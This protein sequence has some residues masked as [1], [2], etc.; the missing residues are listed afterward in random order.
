MSVYKPDHYC[1]IEDN[2][3]RWCPFQV[4]VYEYITS[5]GFSQQCSSIWQYYRQ[6]LFWSKFIPFPRE[7][8][9]RRENRSFC[10]LPKSLRSKLHD[11]SLPYTL[12]NDEQ[13]PSFNVFILVVLRPFISGSFSVKIRPLTTCYDRLRFI[14][15]HFSTTK[16]DRNTLLWKRRELGR[17]LRFTLIY[18]RNTARN[19][20]WTIVSIRL[21][22]S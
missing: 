1:S 15:C 22:R 11:R 18:Y 2:Y 6:E 14:F 12:I 21:R 8:R 7:D 16:H 3:P 20:A 9:L 19:S 17:M 5:T 10:A 13:R 4:H